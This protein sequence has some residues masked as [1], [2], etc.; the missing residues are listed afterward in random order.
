MEKYI[1]TLVFSVVFKADQD[2]RDEAK[3]PRQNEP[4]PV[5]PPF[6]RGAPGPGQ[7]PGLRLPF[8]GQIPHQFP[9]QPIEQQ[10]GQHGVFL[11]PLGLPF[12]LSDKVSYIF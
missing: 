8:P 7:M 5:E 2:Q 3:R 10:P 11:N 6:M 4:D 9:G 1:N 12:P